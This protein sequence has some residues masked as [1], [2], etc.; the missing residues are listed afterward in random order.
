MKRKIN[1][2]RFVLLFFCCFLFLFSAGSIKAAENE[3][4]EK[5]TSNIKLDKGSEV[6]VEEEIEYFFPVA[7]H[8]IFRSIPYRYD[9]EKK[10]GFSR[11]YIVNFK[12]MEAKK[13]NK[14]G[15][16]EDVP[17]SVSQEGNKKVIKIGKEEEMVEGSVKYRLVYSL[18]K[19][20]TFKPEE[21]PN[22]DE[23]FW[24]VTGNSWEV[25][26]KK[27]EAIISFPSDIETEKWAFAC[28]TGKIG[29]T[30]KECLFEAAG[31]NQV[32]FESKWELGVGDGLSVIAGFPRGIINEPTVTENFWF[33]LKYNLIYYIFLLIPL[34][35]FVF[36]FTNWF[37]K[38][39]DPKGKGTIIPFY[40]PPDNLTPVEIGTLFDEKADPKDFSSS[41]IN[42]AVKGYLKIREVESKALFGIF[43]NKPSYQLIVRKDDNLPAGAEKE[44]F[45]V[46][47]GLTASEQKV[48][49]LDQLQNIFPRKID[50]LKAAVYDSLVRKGYFPKSPESVRKN[51]FLVGLIIF[52]VGVI[53]T[54]NSFGLIGAGSLVIT[55]GMIMVFG[56]FMPQKTI[57]GVDAYEKILGLKEYLEV[58]E[59]DRINFHN[60]PAKRPEVFEKLLPYAMILGV[61]KEWAKQFESIY[62]ANPSWYEGGSSLNT[63]NTFYLISALDSFSEV[64]NASMGVKNEGGIASGGGSGFG[65][66]GFSGGGFG[67]GGGGSW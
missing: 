4:I 51:Y 57:K 7:K 34:V 61:E 5:F 36:L 26:I 65:G 22:Q 60:A 6:L 12:F 62:T 20:I 47:L 64:A 31:K 38:G 40:A 50:A 63:F 67:G 66:G 10:D 28:F 43:K 2:F 59:K 49:T 52:I 21:N 1:L 27:S 18:Q 25:P 35:S 19:V 55:G 17:Y 8:G 16:W 46:I 15:V 9:L 56:Y 45:K 54:A 29:S 39:R 23:F 37:L 13:A 24:N 53:F 41:I 3:H 42:L 58:A 48:V 44:I 30:E 11:E 32:K 33:T 14:A